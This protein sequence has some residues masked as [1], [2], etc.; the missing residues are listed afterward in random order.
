M[1]TPA[2][3][4]S[5]PT[6]P[7]TPGTSRLRRTTRLPRGATSISDLSDH[8]TNAVERGWVYGS[9]KYGESQVRTGHIVAGVE[10]YQR[11]LADWVAR[12]G[13]NA[14]ELH[15]LL[16]PGGHVAFVT[17]TAGSGHNAG[18]RFRYRK[19]ADEVFRRDQQQAILELQESFD[20]GFHVELALPLA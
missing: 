16:K 11:F 13:R 10:S 9:L 8:I 18:G 5:V 20:N 4:S 12:G 6:R 3:P 17:A 1:L 2:S 15:R 7:M 19:L 14:A